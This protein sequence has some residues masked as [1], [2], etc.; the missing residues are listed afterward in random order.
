VIKIEACIFDLDG[1]IVDTA[2]HH[3][4]AWREL[5][6]DLG[7][8]FTEKDNEALKGVSRI[9]SLEFLLK[10]S[11][12]A[13]SAEE[14]NKMLEKKNNLYVS[15]I[16]EMNPEEVLPGALEFL[17]SCRKYKIKTAL[18]SASKNARTI[19]NKTNLTSYFDSIIDGNSTNKSKPDPEVFILGAKA[20]QVNPEECIVFEDAIAGIEAALAC[21]MK[22]IGI[23]TKDILTKA[24]YVVPSLKEIH[25]KD[26]LTHSFF[27]Q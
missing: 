17:K 11:N 5:C 18:G 3:Y 6:T 4:I 26:I 22:T 27:L 10:K 21:N 8:E 20:L 9:E 1:V 13:A 16:S 12:S 25:L 15:L 19:L 2:K 7:F 14:K 23:G 24:H